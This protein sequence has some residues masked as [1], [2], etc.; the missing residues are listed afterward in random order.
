MGALLKECVGA[1]AVSEVVVLPGLAV[2][3][4]TGADGV[5]VDEDLDGA[6]VAGEVSG[7]VVGLGQGVRGDL[8]VVLGRRWG[9]VAKPGLQLEQSHRLLGVVELACDCSSGSMAG[10][11]SPDI[12]ER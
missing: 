3:G 10:N 2:G 12:A 5:A 4:L 8:G 1:V 6:N 11:T 9:A 7:V